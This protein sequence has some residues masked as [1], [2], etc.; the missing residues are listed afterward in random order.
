[1]KQIIIR[2]EE[3]GEELFHAMSDKKWQDFLEWRA[4]YRPVSPTPKGEQLDK[5][6]KT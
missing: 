3:S 1:M 5:K 4:K 2:D 6:D